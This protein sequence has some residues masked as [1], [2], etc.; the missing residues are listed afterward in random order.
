[1]VIQAVDVP[2]VGTNLLELNGLDIVTVGGVDLRPW[3]AVRR[4]SACRTDLSIVTM[5][6]IMFRRR[7]DRTKDLLGSLYRLSGMKTV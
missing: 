7:R 3:E 6:I 4:M 2:T 5:S 1:M